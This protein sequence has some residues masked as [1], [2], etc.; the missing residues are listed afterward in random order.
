MSDREMKIAAA[1]CL[2]PIIL[3]TLPIWL[4]VLI[5]IRIFNHMMDKVA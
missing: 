1:V 2:G 3:L 4:P 5:A